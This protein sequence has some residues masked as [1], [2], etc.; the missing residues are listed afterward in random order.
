MDV[1]SCGLIAMHRA[2]RLCI[3]RILFQTATVFLVALLAGCAAREQLPAPPGVSAPTTSLSDRLIVPGERVGPV[4][5]AGKVDEVVALFGRGTARGLGL[6]DWSVL[7]TWDAMG[8]W[9]VSD[10]GTGNVLWIS[11]DTSGS[12][13]WREHATS[14]GVRL[15][16]HERDVISAMGT[17]E[18][19]FT[20]GGA[21]SL[22][23]DRRGIRFTL[24]DRGPSAG[25][26]GA[27]RI[28]WPSVPRDDM[29]IVPGKRISST[30]VQTPIAQV[31]A[32]LDGGYHREEASGTSRIYYW[33]HLGLSVEEREGRVFS[34]RAIRDRPGDA[35]GL[36][37]ATVEG[38]GDG[39]T[40]DEIKRVYGDPGEIRRCGGW[41]CWV[42]R[43]RGI[44][45]ALDD[46]LRTRSVDVLT[47]SAASQSDAPVPAWEAAR[48]QPARWEQM[49]RAAKQALERGEPAEGERLCVVALQYVGASTLR[50]LD[51]Y[52]S[53]LGRLKRPEA[54]GARARAEKLREVRS[55][56]GGGYLGFAPPGELRA[57]ANLLRELG[58]VADAET[59]MALAA[60]EDH[61]NRA[62]YLRSQMQY[63]GR[64]WRGTC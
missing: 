4:R 57:Y 56:P 64:D 40:G 10:T 3:P 24:P 42:Y 30:E 63:S 44:S 6:W 7:H 46:D 52:A 55:N 60:A 13:P 12:D 33:A 43:S 48:W 2:R 8:V 59:M 32:T 25:Q 54:E 36:R 37:Y 31:L 14:E 50:S 29:L 23:Y 19:T 34:I 1:L 21:K 58:Q 45:F 49:R 17:P 28:V 27:L 16:T 15:G 53:L 62:H 61:A 41:R 51:E 39:S 9:V 38:L 11:I 18:R 47:G 20:E 35:A 22:Y 5:L 26:V